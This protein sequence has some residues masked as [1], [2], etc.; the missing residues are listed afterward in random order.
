MC[1][2]TNA[3]VQMM[4]HQ[5]SWNW[6]VISPNPKS[7]VHMSSF[8]VSVGGYFLDLRTANKLPDTYSFAR[9]R[10]K[11]RNKSNH[12]HNILRYMTYKKVIPTHSLYKWDLWH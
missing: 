7:G 10:A 5:N 4:N 6:L 12:E 9:P 1:T 8:Y 11:L 3:L 2:S